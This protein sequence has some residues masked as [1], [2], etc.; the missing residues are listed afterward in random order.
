MNEHFFK[1]Q[2][3][4]ETQKL[5]APAE[6]IEKTRQRA[7]EEQRR[8]A[9]IRKKRRIYRYAAAAA[10]L[11]FLCI[12]AIPLTGILQKEAQQGTTIY[13]GSQGKEIVLQEQVEIEHSYILP[14]EFTKNTAWEEEIAG[15]QVRFAVTDTDTCMAAFE[16]EK[17]YVIVRS[18]LTDRE[19]FH[20]VMEQILTVRG[21]E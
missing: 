14:V 21:T 7:A 3:T 5:H 17:A 9:A 15:V 16:E 18:Q 1:E 12:A 8:Y 13:L 4:A 20:S 19:A 11:L 6:L 10:A 2:Y